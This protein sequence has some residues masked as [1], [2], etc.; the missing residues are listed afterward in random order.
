MRARAVEEPGIGDELYGGHFI[1]S[2]AANS[3]A[4]R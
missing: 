1:R 2:L 4:I 3:A